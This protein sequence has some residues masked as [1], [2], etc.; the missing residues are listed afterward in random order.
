MQKLVLNK[1][2]LLYTCIW[3]LNFY[4]LVVSLHWETRPLLLCSRPD[5]RPYESLEPP[6]LPWGVSSWTSPDR[7]WMWLLWS[8]SCHLWWSSC[9]LSPYFLSTSESGTCTCVCVRAW[10]VWLCVCVCLFGRGSKANRVELHPLNHTQNN[11]EGDSIN[12]IFPV[13][14][15]APIPSLLVPRHCWS[16]SFGPG[17]WVAQ[18]ETGP[19]PFVW[20]PGVIVKHHNAR[21]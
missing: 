1:N 2:Y 4:S 13:T 18:G 19:L 15:G 20:S 10:C 7:V 6:Y 3:Y 21:S 9:P 16:T 11:Y 14:R 17:L 5:H 12:N 8:L